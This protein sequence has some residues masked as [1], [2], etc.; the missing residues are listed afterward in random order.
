MCAFASQVQGLKVCVSM[1]Q[2]YFY[3]MY[4]D[5]LPVCMS[6]PCACHRKLEESHPLELS[7]SHMGAG[8]GP[9]SSARANA[10][11][12]SVIFPAPKLL[13]FFL[14]LVLYVFPGWPLKRSTPFC[15]LNVLPCPAKMIFTCMCVPVANV[16]Q[17]HVMLTHIKNIN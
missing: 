1:W 14:R 7:S 11:N 5:V 4:M 15:I 9:G 16:C 10:R 13:F 12:C 2:I 6:A 8:T 3:F 17:L